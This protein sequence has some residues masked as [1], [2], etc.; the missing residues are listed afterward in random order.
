MVDENREPLSPPPHAPVNRWQITLGAIVGIILLVTVLATAAVFH[1]SWQNAFHKSVFDLTQRI[2]NRITSEIAYEVSLLF[3]NASSKV[4]LLHQLFTQGVLELGDEKAQETLFLSTLQS[5]PNFSWVTL[6]LPRGDFFGTQR[7]T[8][9]KFRVV[10]RIWDTDAR[11]ARSSERFFQREGEQLI[12]THATTQDVRYFAPD[13]AWYRDAVRTGRRVWTDVYI[14]AS[15]QKPGIDVAMPLEKEGRVVGVVAIGMELDQISRYLGGIE[16]GKSGISFIINRRAELIAYQDVSEVVVADN[17]GEK[18]KLGLLSQARAPM[19]QVA[20]RAQEG[21]DL[22]QVQSLS[23]RVE[24]VDDVEYLVTLAPSVNNDWL[25]GTVIPGKEFVAEVDAIQN[26][27]LLGVGMALLLLCA[28]ALAW[29]RT[30]LVRPLRVTTGLVLRIGQGR[31]WENGEGKPSPIVEIQKLT[32]AMQRM[33]RDL[34]EM[35]TRERQ[36]AETRLSQERSFAQLNHEMR[37]AEDVAGLCRVGLHFLIQAMDAQIGTIYLLEEENR[38]WLQASHGLPSG[39]LPAELDGLEGWLG[40]VLQEK[41]FKL[42]TKIPAENFVIRTGLLDLLPR[43]IVA[44]PLLH[45]EQPFGVLTLGSMHPLTEAQFDFAQRVSDAI[46]VAILGIRAMMRNRDLLS[47]TLRQ[48]EALALSQQELNKTIEQLTQTSTYKS[49]FLANM[50]HEIRTPINAVIG[51]SYLALRTRLTDIQHDYLSKVHSSARALLGIIN[52]I[53]DFSKIEAGGMQMETVPFNLDEV[54][55]SLANMVCTRAE[56][57]GLHVLFSRAPEVPNQLLGDPLRLGQILTNLASNAVKF[58]E[59]GDVVVRVE[60]LQE[61]GE[62]VE[63]RFSVED[64]GIGLTEEQTRQLFNPFSQADASTTRKYGGTGL[65]LSICK[66]LVEMM[67]GQIG[68]ESQWGAGSRFYF[69]AWFG[70]AESPGGVTELPLLDADFMNM[71]VLVV[72]DHERSRQILSTIIESFSWRCQVVD[73]GPVALERIA[74]MVADPQAEPFRLAVINWKMAGMNGLEL[75]RYIKENPSLAKPPRI[76][77][78]TPYS[79]EEVIPKADRLPIDGFVAKPI[80]PSQLL[81]AIMTVFGKQEQGVGRKNRKQDPVQNTEAGQK[82]LGA[83]VLLADDNK[84]NQQVATA[85]LE[86][87]GLQ[88]T[89]VGNGRD[90]V[91]AAGREVFDIALMDI[92]MPEMDGF[93][94]TKAIRQ[95]SSGRRLPIVALTAHAM[96][97]DREKSLQAGMDDHITK[98]IDPDQLFNVLVRWI[99]PREGGGGGAE[100]LPIPATAPHAPLSVELLPGIDREMGLKQ[101]GGNLELFNK[102]LR[103]FHQDYRDVVTTLHA[104]LDRGGR[105]EGLRLIHTIK[106]ISGSLGADALHHTCRDLETAIKGGDTV[107]QE[108][109]LERFKQEIT[110]IFQG[111]AALDM[112]KTETEESVASPAVAAAEQTALQPL[113]QELGELLYA[114]H[115][116]AEEKLQTLMAQLDDP[117]LRAQCQQIQKF[118]EEYEFEQGFALLSQLAQSMAITLTVGNP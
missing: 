109:L 103:E 99:T 92:Q 98:P 6:G 69:T 118:L 40:P 54:M 68:V 9:D 110:G 91:V 12:F 56:E 27:L 73:S 8:P 21:W 60:R 39:Q 5:T 112:E 104:A 70:L 30:F 44:L 62:R 74:E 14:F 97:G 47:E 106:G 71:R 46:T 75:S 43:S 89:V 84:I 51:M 18:L 52:D 37:T 3:G 25:I 26:R 101:V 49:Q 7:Q 50:S 55:D 1:L 82:I 83:K 116:A 66:R 11:M 16:V 36:Q 76:I 41:K 85:L 29:I 20:A 22:T 113:F 58:T 13:R 95:Q 48:K 19:L 61:S 100:T 2:S 67:D 64:S 80:N 88:V 15:S 45:N 63:L 24:K 65:G 87:H 57:K 108:A 107:A 28:L 111:I 17:I 23:S 102:L 115:S 38:L 33:G 96:A 4:T 79:R 10:K 34:L 94:A 114:G 117:A 105:E 59:H 31:G 81:S 35:R 32:Q 78:M 77:L 42:L 90:A 93:Q 72:D 86:G 53:L